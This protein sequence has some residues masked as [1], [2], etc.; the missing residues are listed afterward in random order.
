[1]THVSSSLSMSEEIET[2]IRN[3]VVLPVLQ[4]CFYQS[5]A[6]PTFLHRTDLSF[7]KL[8]SVSGHLLQRSNHDLRLRGPKHPVHQMV[9][10]CLDAF[11][12]EPI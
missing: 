4:G 8:V 12:R 10:I 3:S 1:M 7:T 6:K 2:K 11:T 5:V 9:F